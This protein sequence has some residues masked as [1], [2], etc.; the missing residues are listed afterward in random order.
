MGGDLLV[1]R[2]ALFDDPLHPA[3]YVGGTQQGPVGAVDP[4]GDRPGG[5]G[6]PDHGPRHLLPVLLREHY[7]S[8]GGNHP[9]RLRRR[10]D[11]PC[12][13]GPEPLLTV[14]PP[15]GRDGGAG[16]AFDQAE[17][18]TSELQSRPHLVCRLLLE[19]KKK[20]RS[21]RKSST[22]NITVT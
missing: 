16:V 18:H 19:K 9:T 6:E 21:P 2:G 13:E 5:C 4:R 17:E 10:L 1:V 3:A 20:R 12:L 11:R 7:S 15:D 14:D 8:A 22:G